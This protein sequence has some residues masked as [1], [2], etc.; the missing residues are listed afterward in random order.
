MSHI[1]YC[2]NSRKLHFINP[3]LCGV[4]DC[5]INTIPP[6][7]NKTEITANRLHISIEHLSAFRIYFNKGG[8]IRQP[9]SL[10]VII[11]NVCPGHRGMFST[12]GCSVHLGVTM[13]TSGDFMSHVGEQGDKSLWFILKTRCTEH[14]PMHSWYPP[15]VSHGIPDVLNIP[16]VLMISPNVL[17]VSPGVLNISRCTHDIPRCTNVSPNMLNI[18]RCTHGIPRCTHGIPRCTHSIPRCTH[19]IPR[20]THGIPR[21]T[22][23]IPRCTHDIPRCSEHTLHMV[24]TGYPPKIA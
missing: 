3:I 15:D 17:M 5:V 19:G 10:W 24:T 22:H 4:K 23:G 13:S 8:R 11:H 18:P 16:D 2:E 7:N 6:L 21:C 14:P 12:S 1:F 9:K 20:C